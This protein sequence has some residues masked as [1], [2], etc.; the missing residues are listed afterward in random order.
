MAR[1][2]SSAIYGDSG[3]SLTIMHTIDCRGLMCPLP[4]IQTRLKLNTLHVGDEL[5]ILSDDPT[6]ATDFLRFCQLADLTLVSRVDNAGFQQYH[7]KISR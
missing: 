4:I 7:V 5:T 1:A 2:Y 6:F 3:T